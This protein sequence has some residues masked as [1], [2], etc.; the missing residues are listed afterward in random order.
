MASGN[1]DRL[2]ELERGL[3]A[4]HSRLSPA[5]GEPPCLPAVHSEPLRDRGAGKP[6][7][8]AEPAQ[9]EPLELR[10]PVGRQRKQRER[11]RLEELLLLLLL[12]E[13]DLARVGRRSQRQGP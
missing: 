12:H 6:R 2:G 4:A 9:T 8:L 10:V 13:H 1:V 5:L 7:E 11:Q 3:A